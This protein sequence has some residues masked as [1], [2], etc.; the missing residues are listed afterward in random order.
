MEDPNDMMVQADIYKIQGAG[1]MPDDIATN[2]T[3]NKRPDSNNP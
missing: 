2:E 1:L 3:I